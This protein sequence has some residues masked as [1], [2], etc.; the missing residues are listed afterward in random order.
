MG[1]TGP[2]GPIGPTGPTGASGGFGAY[3]NFV[4]TVTQTNTSAGNP[5]PFRL[6]TTL[7]SG[8]VTIVDDT[9]IT[10]DRSGLFNIAFSAQVTKT[11]PGTDTIYIWLRKN[12]VDVPDSSTGLVLV[13]AGAKQVAAWNFFVD[14]LAGQHAT[15]MWGSPDS[16]AQILYEGP[17]TNP[18]RPAIPSVIITV[19]QVG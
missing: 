6:R 17:G 3:G 19:N 1:P 9:K 8:G 18:S 16:A 4:D 15:L 7:D 5:L 14:L 10:V 2:T 11:D 12:G 13:G